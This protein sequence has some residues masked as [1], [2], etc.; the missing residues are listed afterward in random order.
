MK[1]DSHKGIFAAC[2]ESL[3]PIR[4]RNVLASGTK[5]VGDGMLLAETC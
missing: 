2:C 5:G 4:L 3:R 1:S